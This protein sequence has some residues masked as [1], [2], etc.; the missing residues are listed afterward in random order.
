METSRPTSKDPG[1]TP[2]Y[3]GKHLTVVGASAEWM[4]AMKVMAFREKDL[5]DIKVLMEETGR[6]EPEAVKAL[7]EKVYGNEAPGALSL[8]KLR[9][10]ALED[11][12]RHGRRL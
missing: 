1:E 12:L 8:I 9:H 11:W 3:A 10:E 5:S 7:M 2:L 4:L 6:H